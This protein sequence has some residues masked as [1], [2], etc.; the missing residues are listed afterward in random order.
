MT[1]ENLIQL[2]IAITLFLTFVAVFLYAQATIKLWKE[3]VKQTKE[4]TKQT[5]LSMRPIVVITYDESDSKFKFINY[6]NTPA[7]SIK[8]DD[9]TLINTEG[10][11]FEYVFPEEHF[12]PQPSL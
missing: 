8:I 11:R 2:S 5:R 6:G 10:L 3:T 7:F 4:M 1:C 12:L 9:V